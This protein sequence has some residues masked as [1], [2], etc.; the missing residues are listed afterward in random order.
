[1]ISSGAGTT[2]IGESPHGAARRMT[3]SARR[4]RSDAGVLKRRSVP[5][6]WVHVHAVLPPSRCPL[7]NV[8]QPTT[9]PSH[10]ASLHSAGGTPHR[11]RLKTCSTA[12]CRCR[13]A[14]CCTIGCEACGVRPQ[15]NHDLPPRLPTHTATCAGCRSIERHVQRCNVTCIVAKHGRGPGAQSAG[16]HTS[17]WNRPSS[18]MLPDVTQPRFTARHHF[19]GG[20]GAGSR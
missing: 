18:M 10:A 9:S 12:R 4:V 6:A 3:R 1:M 16:R 8:T 13:T 7:P 20:T 5:A 2:W 17:G 19:L 14:G 15:V 11:A